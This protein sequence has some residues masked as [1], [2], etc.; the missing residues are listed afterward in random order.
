MEVQDMSSFAEV[1]LTDFSGLLATAC[2]PL[3]SAWG[4]RTGLGRPD[5]G[6]SD[7]PNAFLHFV[8]HV[9]AIA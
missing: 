8:L 3:C 4:I 2:W 7:T 6:Q 1:R 5:L 9:H